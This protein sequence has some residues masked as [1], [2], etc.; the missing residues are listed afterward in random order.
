M[1]YTEK[2]PRANSLESSLTSELVVFLGVL[3]GLSFIIYVVKR[4][5]KSMK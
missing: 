4:H 2:L 5:R 1:S 3:G